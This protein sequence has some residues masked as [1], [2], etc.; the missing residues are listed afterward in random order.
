[1][2]SVL[3]FHHLGL[4][5]HIMCHGIVREYCK[6]YDRVAIF[7]YP[8]NYPSV[9][10]MFRDLQNLT[11]IQ[12]DIESARACIAKNAVDRTYDEV[13]ILGFENLN[14]I[15]G[16]A[17]EKQFYDL[18]DV[19]LAKKWESFYVE[20][21]VQ[22]E[23]ELFDR[24]APRGD[25]AFVHEDASRKYLIKRKYIGKQYAVFLPSA[26]L[27]D[28]IFDYCTIIEKAKEIHVI[29]SSFMF[30]ID[31]LAYENP[32]QKLYVHRYSRENNEWQLPI[33]KKDWYILNTESGPFDPL[34]NFLETLYQSKIF[35]F[36][37][38]L[39]RRTVRRFFRDMG[40]VMGRPKRPDTASLIQRHTQGKSFVSIDSTTLATTNPADVVFYTGDISPSSS[41]AKLL[42]KL[43][44]I[45]KETLIL[46]TSSVL[47]QSHVG[48][49]P[50]ALETMLEQARF[51]VREKQIFP[52]ETCFVCRAL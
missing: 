23:K 43:R 44:S 17:L 1:M 13:K 46:D 26:A 4:G 5:D 20:R 21:D 14:R 7:S 32:N 16:I 18:A 52:T 30:M 10:F 45:T 28:N 37:T 12:G 51:G 48:L 9:S 40:W 38:T 15:D 22:R 35:L 25:Y 33:L 41:S 6:K 19:P 31:C 3:L 2:S 11:I 49:T 27:T 42:Q 36:N 34:K 50:Q 29:D 8:H 24:A 47:N 39:F